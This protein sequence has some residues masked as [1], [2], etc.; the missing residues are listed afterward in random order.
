MAEPFSYFI[1]E[2]KINCRNRKHANIPFDIDVKFLSELWD[3]QNGRCAISNIPM[4]YHAKGMG[5]KSLD[6]A[7]LDRIDSD[8][9]YTKDNVQFV[10]MAINLAKNIH[11]NEDM[12]S[13]LDKVVDNYEKR[14][15]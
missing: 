3:A 11:S 8:K 4:K 13:F 10:A 6:S 1:T 5:R 14:A 2:A 9:G 15:K 12:R 7:S